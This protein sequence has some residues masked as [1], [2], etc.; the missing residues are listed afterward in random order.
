MPGRRSIRATSRASTRA[1]RRPADALRRAALVLA[2]DVARMERLPG[3]LRHRV[4]EDLHA[5]G[6]RVDLDVDQM[7]AEAGPRALR[8]DPPDAA[9]RAAG[10]ARHL[11]HVGD[12][13]RLRLAGQ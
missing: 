4:A 1:A 12:G 5:P 3:I 11:G 6:L 7:R 10:L 9:D 2:L 13:H 8:I